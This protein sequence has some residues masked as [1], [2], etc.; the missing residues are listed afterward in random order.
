MLSFLETLYSGVLPHLWELG[1]AAVAIVSA[2]LA[3]YWREQ[4]RNGTN[5]VLAP[6]TRALP[7]NKDD[8]PSTKQTGILA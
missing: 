5:W 3:A 7:W 2:T 1:A 6:L 4:A 8:Q